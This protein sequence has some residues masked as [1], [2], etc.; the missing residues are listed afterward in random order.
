MEL[1]VRA[2]RTLMDALAGGIEMELKGEIDPVTA[3][4]RQTERYLVENISNKFPDH[5]FLAEEE[6][7]SG[8][9]SGFRWVIDPIDGTTNFAHGY[10]CFVISL[11]LEHEG[12][13]ILGVIQPSRPPA[14]RLPPP[15]AV[16][17]SWASAG[18]R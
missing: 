14:R 13:A 3:L 5:D 8:D 6:T 4:D 12:R 9:G 10:P 2:G 16:V 18:S 7:D 17:R 11:A 15:T 1:A